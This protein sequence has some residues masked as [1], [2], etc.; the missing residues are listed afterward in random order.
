M[1][2]IQHASIFKRQDTNDSPVFGFGL[3]FLLCFMCFFC[4]ICVTIGMPILPKLAN[5]FNVNKDT[6]QQI[7]SI[8][9]LGG[10]LSGLIYGPLSD[11]F[12]RRRILL[13]TLSLYC[14]FAFLSSLATTI[15]FFMLFQFLQ[16]LHAGAGTVVSLAIAKDSLQGSAAAK[17][18][19]NFGLIIPLAPATGPLI[20]G[21]LES[22]YGWQAVYIFLS[23]MA[24]IT[25]LLVLFFLPETHK[26]EKRLSFSYKLL[27]STFKEILRKRSFLKYAMVL[28]LSHSCLMMYNVTASFMFIQQFGIKL[29]NFG[30]YQ[31]LSM[32]GI[33]LG[34]FIVSRFVMEHGLTKMLK[35]GT[36]LCFG[37]AILFLIITIEDFRIPVLFSLCMF[38]FCVGIGC[39]FSTAMS[40]GM[41]TVPEA[42]GC[43][44]SLLRL[45]QLTASSISVAVIAEFYNQTFWP[46]VVVFMTFGL[47]LFIFGQYYLSQGEE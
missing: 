39:I 47:G 20:G 21:Y 3:N 32:L 2:I 22:H 11:S 9:F 18:I 37:G 28:G 25:M 19:A 6:A 23:I 13:V 8:L 46:M 33:I 41:S 12:G 45:M 42:K 1:S 31:M 17:L 35:F 40:L 24:G 27:V 38:V 15:E 4:V 26:K 36:K 30:F 44:S 29:E 16:G 14:L 7:A 5:Y 10:G 43:T 34:N